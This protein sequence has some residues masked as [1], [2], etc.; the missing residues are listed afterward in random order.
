[1]SETIMMTLRKKWQSILAGDLLKKLSLRT[2]DYVLFVVLGA[3]LIG[4]FIF[5]FRKTEF[6]ELRVKVTDR[7]LLYAR[8]QPLSWFAN[9]FQIGD[10]EK[11]ALG[12]IN[13]QIVDVESFDVS[14][15]R[16]LRGDY[17]SDSN[18]IPRKVVYLT[19]QTRA[20]YDSRSKA[21]SIKGQKLAF[22]TP[23]QFNFS[24]I[25]FDGLVT[26]VNN[27]QDIYETEVVEL[28][29][30][31]LYPSREYSDVYGVL[32]EIAD[33]VKVGDKILDSNKNVLV[34]I[35][36]N[37]IVPAR[38]I[39]IT[40]M[41][42]PLEVTDPVLKDVT[43]TILLKTK[44]FR[45]EIYAFDDIPV[46]IGSVLPLNFDHISVFPTITKLLDSEE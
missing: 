9:R 17:F 28:E 8:T 27:I 24:T 16:E 36:S 7:D 19:I 34:K 29:A 12:R 43:Y 18:T 4:V 1:M 26:D 46:K 3:V 44:V 37:E 5:L 11:D 25:Q 15:P 31:L 23:L 42:Q 22:G 20:V 13:S 32:P 39:V 41:G 6:V 2:I 33:A 14:Q 21:Y 35:E 30:K 40:D 45:N 10:V 38:R